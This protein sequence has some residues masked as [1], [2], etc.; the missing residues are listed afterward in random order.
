MYLLKNSTPVW[1]GIDWAKGSGMNRG[2]VYK[3]EN[4]V[5][6]VRFKTVGINY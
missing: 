6:Y 5:L 1:I 2:D 4:N 3:R